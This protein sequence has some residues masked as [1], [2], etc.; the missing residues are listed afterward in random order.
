MKTTLKTLIASLPVT[1]Y[2]LRIFLHSSMFNINHTSFGYKIML[3]LLLND[4]EWTLHMSIFLFE[5]VVVYMIKVINKQ[6]CMQK[7]NFK[8]KCRWNTKVPMMTN[9]RWQRLQGK[10]LGTSRNIC[11]KK[12]SCETWKNIKI[13]SRYYNYLLFCFNLRFSQ[14]FLKRISWNFQEMCLIVT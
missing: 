14:P 2:R 12:C 10:Y 13:S 3:V 4:I 9:N 5:Y 8:F 6:T 11:H 1:L 7:S